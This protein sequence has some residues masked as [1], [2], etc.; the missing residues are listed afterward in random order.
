MESCDWLT[1]VT[2]HNQS[3]VLSRGPEAFTRWPAGGGGRLGDHLVAR[4]TRPDVSQAVF[5]RV[6]LGVRGHLPHGDGT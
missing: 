6:V 3:M 1:V 4:G 2:W 5:A